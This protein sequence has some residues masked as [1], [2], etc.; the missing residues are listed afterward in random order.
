M[1]IISVLMPYSVGTALHAAAMFQSNST[2]KLDGSDS[3]M[4]VYPKVSKDIVVVVYII[5]AHLVAGCHIVMAVSPI[6]VASAIMHGMA[7]S[8]QD[9]FPSFICDV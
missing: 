8:F 1:L 5:R 4:V 7:H 3:G 9:F 2:C 6:I